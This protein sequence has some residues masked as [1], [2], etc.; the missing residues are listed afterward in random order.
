LNAH[1]T[2]V[3]TIEGEWIG[4]WFEKE[5]HRAEFAQ[6]LKK[7]HKAL[8]LNEK[9]MERIHQAA[10]RIHHEEHMKDLENTIS[11]EDLLGMD[12]AK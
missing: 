11:P 3:G 10:E 1:F 6:M 5:M 9:Q 12:P 8:E 4:F 7:F 2:A